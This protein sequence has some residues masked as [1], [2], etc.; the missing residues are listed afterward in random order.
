MTY[1]SYRPSGS[2]SL[3]PR[4]LPRSS[5]T[6]INGALYHKSSEET[7][8]SHEGSI[9]NCSVHN[10]TPAIDE[11]PLELSGQDPSISDHKSLHSLLKTT[12]NFRNQ[13]LSTVC[14]IRDPESN[15][16]STATSTLRHSLSLS[17]LD[18][19]AESSLR[20]SLAVSPT[21]ITDSRPSQDSSPVYAVFTSTHT[22]D[23]NSQLS[24][25]ME[26]METSTTYTPSIRPADFLPRPSHRMGTTSRSSPGMV[27]LRTTPPA[28]EVHALTRVRALHSFEPT[29]SDELAFEKGDIIKVVNREYKDWW[30][31]Q[32]N[33]FTGI[34]PVN[35]VVRLRA[36]FYVCLCWCLRFGGVQETLPEPTSAE[37]AAEALQDASVYSQAAN[38]D[39]LLTMLRTLDPA[40]DNLADIEVIQELYHDC[41]FLRPK[42]VKLIN[43]Y[44]QKCGMLTSVN[45]ESLPE[46][47]ISLPCLQL[48]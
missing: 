12:Y 29:E 6:S 10:F 21:L 37:L 16:G 25:I 39:R 8:R 42:I 24:S 36:N 32:L 38:A 26:I 48:I 33:D 2:S 4:S 14:S 31:G 47:T 23:G 7:L 28:A 40:K 22:D 1:D 9:S 34:F 11:A 44:S 20:P 45:N 43:K 5:C 15:R 18:D 30:R 3:S 13:S 19:E 17:S 41:M 35:Y 46:L 27:T